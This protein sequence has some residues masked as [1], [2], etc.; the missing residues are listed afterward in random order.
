MLFGPMT[1]LVSHTHENTPV[2]LLADGPTDRRKKYNNPLIDGLTYVQISRS[3][4]DFCVMTKLF[5][6][7][8]SPTPKAVECVLVD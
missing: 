3:F 8:V 4:H 1:A 6:R 5:V 7:R 2:F